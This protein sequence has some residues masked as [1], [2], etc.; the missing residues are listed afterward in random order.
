MLDTIIEFIYGPCLKNQQ[1]LGTWKKLISTINTLMDQKELG[2]YSGIHP[3]IKA[4]LAILYSAS[5]VLLAICDIKDAQEAKL[6]HA[7]ILDQLNIENM[8]K[9][10]VDIFVY[11]IGGNARKMNIYNYD[12]QCKHYGKTKGIDGSPHNCIEKE[13]CEFGHMIPRD[14]NTIQTGFNIYQ[15]L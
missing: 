4:Q 8:I 12:I 1:S 7:I 3:Q 14:K 13:Y 5:Q 2:N 6:T 10:M 15:I 11:K 9:K